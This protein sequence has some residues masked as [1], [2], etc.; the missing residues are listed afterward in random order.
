[1]ARYTIVKGQFWIH[2][3]DR[4]R[5][6]P[7]PDGDTVTFHP[8]DPQIVRGL[9]W[10]SGRGPSFN[11]RGNI[12]VRY[13]GVDAL[14]THFQGTHQNL[15]FANAARAENLRLLGF[16]NVRYFADLPNV[17]ESVDGNPL[18]GYVIANGI[19]SNGRLLGLVYA[20]S[21]PED[22]GA[23]IF[24]DGGRLIQS[25]NSKLVAAGLAYVEPYDT[26]P[27]TLIE[28]LRQ[29]TATA[30]IGEDGFFEAEDVSK[31]N[32]ASIPDLAALQRLVMW[33]KL[34]RRLVAYFAEG[35]KGLGQFDR[36]LRQDPVHRDDS[37]RLPNGEKGNMHDACIINGNSLQLRYNPEDLLIA[38]DPSP[39]LQAA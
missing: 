13:E 17:V 21:P 12:P 36:W 2:Y 39:M 18:T 11:A 15:D 38:P 6:G 31:A 5:Q 37:L 3:P 16:E 7:Q 24:L 4:P 33:P 20:G 1:M 34:F 26:M 30:R 8:D 19:E 32:A 9:P 22:D 35:N 23:N 27:M 29:V 28:T 10:F 14:E 25:V